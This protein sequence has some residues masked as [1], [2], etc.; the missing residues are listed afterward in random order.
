MPPA[1]SGNTNP[2]H[3]LQAAA[4]GGLN[5]EQLARL[6]LATSDPRGLKAAILVV[7][8]N[9]ELRRTIVLKL[10]LFGYANVAT[11]A[12]GE[13]ALELIQAREFDLLILDIEMPRVNGFDVLRALKDDP[14][15]R[16]LPV[17]VSSGLD[18]LDAVVRCIELGAE[19]YL[20]KPLKAVIFRARVGATLERKRLRDI[21]RLRLIQVQHERRLLELEQEKS[22]RLLLNVLP[23]TIAARLKQGE[24]TIAERYEGVTVLFAD[25]VDFSSLA[26]R[27]EPEDLVALLNDLFSRFDQLAGRYGLEKIKT[28]GDSY[29]AVGGLPERRPDHAEAIAGMALEMLA[30]LEAF[31]R[32][33]SSQLRMRIGLN[34]GPVVAGIIGRQK[35]SYDLWGSTVNLASRMQSSGVPG[36]IQ[37]SPATHALLQGKFEMAARGTVLCKGLGE[38]NTYLLQGR[39]AA[40]GAVLTP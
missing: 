22:E 1:R 2:F 39:I 38:V 24:R 37:V 4:A 33:R 40:Q 35:F 14:A 3:L 21:E 29:L 8:D 30:A 17:I 25:V 11:A 23:R 7:D 34:S 5:P 31:N 28:I 9:D 13:E 10:E 32:D 16:H 12:N 36:A 26:S 15:N 19:D 20:M 6:E 27:T 18:D